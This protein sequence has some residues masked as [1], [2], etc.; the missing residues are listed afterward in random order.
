[1]SNSKIYGV[2]LAT[3]AAT[4]FCTTNIAGAAEPAAPAQIKCSGVNAC[5][6]K[7]DCASATNACKGQ[8][9]CKG[10]GW[11]NMSKSDCVTKGGTVMTEEHK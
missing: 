10:H 4:W 11:I 1:M 9:S 6:G 8:N 7:S 2:L 5:K 3:A